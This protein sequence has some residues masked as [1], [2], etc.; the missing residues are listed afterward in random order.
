MPAINGN[1][2]TIEGLDELLD[3]LRTQTPK[4]AT[5]YLR[6]VTARAGQVVLDAMDDTVPVEAG[7]LRGNLIMKKV[8][9]SD[10]LDVTLNI[11]PR[12]GIFWGSLTEFGHDVKTG[13]RQGKNKK[14][15][16]SY[17]KDQ[18]YG[19]AHVP[20]THWMGNAWMSTQDQVLAVF[21][22]EAEIMCDTLKD[23]QGA[24]DD[25]GGV[26]EE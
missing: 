26:E 12:K 15:N 23:A 11:G 4:A 9:S 3:L 18:E 22:A 13:K 5:R 6:K 8:R 19:T 10:P 24:G 1:S 20:G 25:D 14:G 2:V 16:L 21:E 17:S 7:T